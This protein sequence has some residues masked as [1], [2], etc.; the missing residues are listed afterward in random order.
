MLWGLG[1]MAM[2]MTTVLGAG[3]IGIIVWASSERFV[4]R[5]G[6]LLVEDDGK[7]MPGQSAAFTR[8][9]C[10]YWEGFRTRKLIAMPRDDRCPL[11]HRAT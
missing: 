11:V 6:G 7:R 5:E 10:T 3:G 1:V 4:I 9:V 2:L 8:T